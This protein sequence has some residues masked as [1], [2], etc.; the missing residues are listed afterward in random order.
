MEPLLRNIEANAAIEPIYSV[1]LDSE[2]PKVY[3]YADDVSSVIRNSPGGTQALFNEYE[4]LTRKSGLELNAD[5]TEILRITSLPNERTTITISYLGEEHEIE[6]CNKTKING[7]ILQQDEKR[8]K[9]ENLQ[10]AIERMQA[11]FKKWTRRSLSTLGKILLVKTYGIS[12]I[13]YLLQSL[14]VDDVDVKQ[15]NAVL[16]KF[17]WNRNYMAPK[18][19]E[20]LKRE[21]VNKPIALGG[22]GMLNVTELDESL[23]LKALGRLFESS[24]PFLVV[25]R[26]KINLNEFFYPECSVTYDGVTTA[27]INLLRKDRQELIHR[28]DLEGNK[29]MLGL[30]KELRIK[31][32]VIKGKENSLL[33]FNLRIRGCWKVGHLNETQINSLKPVMDK[34]LHDRLR[35]VVLSRYNG[36]LADL[37]HCYFVNNAFKALTKLSSKEIRTSRMN[38]EPIC[39]YKVGLILSPNESINWANRVRKLTSTKLKDTML[40]IAHGEIYTKE[41]L[42]RFGLV[43]SEICPRCD[44]VETLAHKFFKC[45]YVKEIWKCVLATTNKLRINPIDINSLDY[46][47]PDSFLASN[48]DNNQ[49]I[50]TLQAEILKR[51]LSLSDTQDYLIHPKMLVRLATNHL[52]KRER[53]DL[54]RDQLKALLSD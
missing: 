22:L 50:M 18:A 52:I 37:S 43:D 11:T 41:K 51:I 49:A 34:K 17:I 19:P 38:K 54:L 13:I 24:H 23:K 44:Q 8:M 14:T 15:I 28:E 53:K 27:G 31:R 35:K 29:T 2:L 45:E 6:T 16:Y 20:R 5:K 39:V 10:A 4:R 21:I 7:L 42:H 9:K 3:A 25:I 47:V 36:Q 26:N 33:V 30:L 48:L 40:R 46:D 32:V 12:Q 1:E